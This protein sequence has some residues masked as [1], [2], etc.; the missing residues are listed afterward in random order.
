MKCPRV[1]RK[2]WLQYKPRQTYFSKPHDPCP[3]VDEDKCYGLFCHFDRCSTYH[4]KPGTGDRKAPHFIVEGFI[5]STTKRR[6]EPLFITCSP[7]T[8]QLRTETA[9]YGPGLHRRRSPRPAGHGPSGQRQPRP[10]HG[11]HRPLTGVSLP[12]IPSQ[13]AAWVD[14]VEGPNDI[15]KG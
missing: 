1:R 14:S 7:C 11:F 8:W 2:T 13:A 5:C 3:Q 9:A 6:L 12:K 15:D 10:M 4:T